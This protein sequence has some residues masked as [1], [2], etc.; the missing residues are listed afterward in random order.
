[1]EKQWCVYGQMFAWGIGKIV[2]ESTNSLYIQ[3]TEGQFYSPECWDPN[4]VKRFDTLEEAMDE[5][6]KYKSI[7]IFKLKE[8]VREQFPSYYKRRTN[9]RNSKSKNYQSK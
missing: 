6:L 1:M 3:Y 5:Y 9:V 8:I 7:P 2:K 4:Y